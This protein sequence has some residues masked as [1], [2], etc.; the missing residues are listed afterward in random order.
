V[1]N[2]KLIKE[3][4]SMLS[5]ESDAFEGLNP[6]EVIEYGYE[7]VYELAETSKT[8]PVIPEAISLLNKVMAELSTQAVEDEETRILYYDL[9]N[10]ESISGK[11]EVVELIK[12]LLIVAVCVFGLWVLFTVI[13]EIMKVAAFLAVVAFG[14]RLTL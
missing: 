14:I 2:A 13:L 5:L 3:L 9:Y 11:E 7:L 12:F 10:G 6:I 8:A 4:I 1:T